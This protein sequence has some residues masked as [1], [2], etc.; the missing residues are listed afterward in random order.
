MIDLYS[1][2]TPNGHK[3]SI[4]LE[5]MNLPYNLINIDLS[6]EKYKD[7]NFL[8]ISPN[9]KIPAI[10]D[11]ENGI[12]VFES[13]AILIYLAEKTNTFIPSDKLNRFM[14]LQWLFFQTSGIGPMQGQSNVF[15]EYF[16]EKLP[17]VIK[18]YQ[19]ECIRLYRVL[20]KQLEDKEYICGDISIAD[21][22]TFPW[23]NLY[24]WAGLEITDFSNIKNWLQRCNERPALIKGLENPIWK[25]NKQEDIRVG[26]KMIGGG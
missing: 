15:L 9:G 26:K 16:P 11:N 24:K 8:S 13:G 25:N 19:N 22:A 1:A 18:R 17:S 21:F 7:S 4:A 3:I 12:S 6:H 10:L 14:V 2:P 23:V 20:N 5:E